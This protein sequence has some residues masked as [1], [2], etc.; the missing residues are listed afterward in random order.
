MHRELG[1]ADTG[2]GFKDLNIIQ[3]MTYMA[4]L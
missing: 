3:N 1:G 4:L 2:T